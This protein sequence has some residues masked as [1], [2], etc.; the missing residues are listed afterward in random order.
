MAWVRLDAPNVSTVE[1]YAM[2][3]SF[4]FT[5]L[6]CALPMVVPACTRESNNAA[7]NQS[8][9]SSQTT[10][11]QGSPSNSAS[12]TLDAT[13]TA[14]TTPADTATTPSGA[15]ATSQE[16]GEDSSASATE[17]AGNPSK[18]DSNETSSDENSDSSECA[19]GEQQECAELEN[20]AAVT[21]PTGAP[22]GSCKMGSKTCASGTWGKCIGTVAPKAQDRCDVPGDDSN[23][24]G[25]PN[26][27]CACVDGE[28]RPCGHNE[29]G[30]CKLGTQSCVG[31][32]WSDQCVG[33]ILPKKERCDGKN[34]D[35]DC[36]GSADLDDSSCECID[37]K[38][39]YC[40]RS[41][42]KGDC[43]WG[44]KSCEQGKWTRCKE[45]ARPIDE[46]C[47]ER[48]RISGVKWTGDEDCDGGVDT[49]PFGRP[50]PSGCT[51]MMMDVDGDGFGRVGK[52]LSQ[53]SKGESLEKLATA[54]LCTSRP[55]MS[56]K[57]RE[58]WVQV[59]NG[60]ANTDCGDCKDGGRQVQPTLPNRVY[61][62]KFD[63]PSRCLKE[64][65][66]S[67]VFDYNCNGTEEPEFTG[68]FSCDFDATNGRCVKTGNWYEGEQPDCG[69]S[70][71]HVA[72]GSSCR[73]VD[74]T[75]EAAILGQLPQKKQSCG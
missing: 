57:Y 5:L 69:Q 61:N 48:A 1:H 35:E 47:G 58:G 9:E 62:E 33:A 49:S 12:S 17:S 38:E 40:Q 32:K 75:C 28:T 4:R 2:L 29:V 73:L 63:Q 23:C 7:Q 44:K 59:I 13:Q 68:E 30:E 20:G 65:G 42:Q 15:D 51:R 67:Q 39:E 25:T 11:N 45:W 41:G 54:C 74:D 50:G 56:K 19:N 53:M 64:V 43:K 72:G 46:I 14:E 18:E 22:L 6:A 55:D 10:Q 71:D 21:F 52:D 31:G 34:R 26:S 27:G 3:E 60:R 16:P 8:G 37:G 36:N 70:A 24:D 66:Y